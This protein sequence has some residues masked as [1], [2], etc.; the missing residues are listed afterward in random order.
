MASRRV[1]VVMALAAVITAL[2]VMSGLATLKVL[3]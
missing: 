1:R 2:A 3:W